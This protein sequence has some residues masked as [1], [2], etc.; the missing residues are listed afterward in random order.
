[1][2]IDGLEGEEEEAVNM[3]NVGLSRLWIRDLLVYRVRTGIVGDVGHYEMNENYTDCF[4]S[5]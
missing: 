4:V 3:Q 1:M 5:L 2:A